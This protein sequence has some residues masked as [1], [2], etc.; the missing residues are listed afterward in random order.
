MSRRSSVSRVRENRTHGLKGDGGTGLAGAPR[1]QLPMG[2]SA[3]DFA[4]RVAAPGDGRRVAA[5]AALALGVEDEGDPSSDLSTVIDQFGGRIRL[6]H[7]EAVCR[8]A[9]D[10][11]GQV[12]GIVHAAP[13]VTWIEQHPKA[14]HRALARGFTKVELLAVSPE[15]Q[16]TGVGSALLA[17]LEKAERGRSTVV[18]FANINANDQLVRRWYEHRGYTVAYGGEP[19]ALHVGGELVTL[20][21]TDDGYLIAGKVIQQGM[22]LARHH[23]GDGSTC[24]LVEKTQG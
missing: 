10:A 21:D 8:V 5:L 18:L 12:T 20:V 9:E 24:L 4:I 11:Q 15:R 17:E 16:N 6:S 1:L 14:M 23:M 22:R 3:T 7:G 19:T 13:P 2:T